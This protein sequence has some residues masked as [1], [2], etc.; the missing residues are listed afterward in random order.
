MA[1]H[2]ICISELPAASLGCYGEVRV[3]TPNFDSL[4]DISVVFNAFF[5]APGHPASVIEQADL[6]KKVYQWQPAPLDVATL[7]KATGCWLNESEITAIFTPE[8]DDDTSVSGVLRRLNEVCPDE[9]SQLVQATAT[10][11]AFDTALGEFVDGLEFEDDDLLIVVGNSGDTRRLPRNR[12][13]WLAEVSSTSI[14]LPLLVCSPGTG[15]HYRVENRIGVDEF[16]DLI[17]ALNEEGFAAI[18]T[19]QDD[20]D[21]GPLVIQTASSL[22]TR[23]DEWL[24]VE[25]IANRDEL[26]VESN[27]MLFRKPE[28]LWETQDVASQYPDLIEE[29][30]D[31]RTSES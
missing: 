17:E 10:V 21:E 23:S 15:T 3:P 12:P 2:F 11:L 22:A 4:A 24:I 28:D 27:V 9:R 5:S 8:A 19:W 13:D 18:E 30:L 1:I 16:A 7:F 25:R 26:D 31:G 6:P 20:L 29:Y 14:H